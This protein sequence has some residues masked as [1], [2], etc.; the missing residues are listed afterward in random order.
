MNQEI[1]DKL[2]TA[3]YAVAPV[4]EDRER[5]IGEMGETIWVESLE[6]MLNVLPEDKQKEVVE[7]L[8]N[9]DLDKAVEIFDAHNVDI[10][11]IITEVSTD[12]MNDVMSE[13]QAA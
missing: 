8:N 4:L 7:L 3:L 11:A 10:D 9:D 2:H 12:V 13:V 1:I 5:L 6:K